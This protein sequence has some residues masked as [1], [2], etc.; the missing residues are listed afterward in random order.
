MPRPSMTPYAGER[1]LRFVGDRVRF[2]LLVD[3]MPDGWR[4]LLR[5][6]LGRAESAR[7]EMIATL[8]GARSFAGLS[9]RDIPLIRDR[10]GWLLDL[11]LTEV[12]YFRAK[13]YAVDAAGVQHWP[14]G[15]DIGISVHPDHYRTAN[16]V[17]C[18]FVRMFGQGK[19]ARGTRVGQ[20]DDQFA[21]LD[22]HGYTIIPPSGKLRDLAREIPHI[23][24][25]LGCR[26]I[27]LLPV[28]ATPTTYA[29]FGR[30]GSPYA[31]LDLTEIDPALAVFDQRTTVVDQ[32][33]EVTYA[34]HLR[35]ARVFLDVVVN[36]TGWG[37]RLQNARPEWFKRKADGAFHSP[38]AWGTTWED[39]VELDNRFPA[40]WEEFAESF[41]TWCRRG[42]DG[43][44][45]DAGY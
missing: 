18:A 14:D 45:C 37:S 12:G 29:R 5:T 15:D 35:G 34:A 44:R 13:P 22:K 33:R 24:S 27:H 25:T 4:G 19:D 17:Y 3:G 41:L 21:A 7:N 30:F 36:H 32:F 43:F 20:L 38:G 31:A 40:L 10:D 9:W 16:T 6:N 39:L 26:I 42:V 1:L 23:V 28:C 11:P 2:S 8:G